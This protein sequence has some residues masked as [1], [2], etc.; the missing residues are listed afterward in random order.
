MNKISSP[1]P[2][3]NLPRGYRLSEGE[4][5]SVPALNDTIP[6]GSQHT[7][8]TLAQLLEVCVPT[9]GPKPAVLNPSYTLET[10]WMTGIG[11]CSPTGGGSHSLCYMDSVMLFRMRVGLY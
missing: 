11:V 9:F 2:G 5:V 10:S 1:M 6:L 4:V 3:R 7:Q 8:P